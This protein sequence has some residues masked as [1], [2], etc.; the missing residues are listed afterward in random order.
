M[1]SAKYKF[2]SNLLKLSEST[3]FDTAKTEWITIPRENEEGNA[4]CLCQ[5]RIKNINYMCNTRT[6]KIITITDYYFIQLLYIFHFIS[7]QG[8]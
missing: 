8:F 2:E 4:L 5:H 6:N 7:C 1:S 3:D